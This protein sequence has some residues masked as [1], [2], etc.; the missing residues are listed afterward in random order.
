MAIAPF[1]PLG[2]ESFMEFHGCHSASLSVPPQ[3]IHLPDAMH[4]GT[5]T[6]L[7]SLQCG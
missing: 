7:D 5:K 6:K 2:N 1:L 4:V 3:P